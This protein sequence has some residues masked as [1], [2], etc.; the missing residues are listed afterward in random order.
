[1]IVAPEREVP[2]ISASACAKAEL[3]GVGQRQIVDRFDADAMF[4]RSAQRMIKPPT[5]KA[6]P[7]P[8][9]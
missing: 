1:M 8:A 5:M 6:A 2:G 9:R 3:E 7:R 4:A